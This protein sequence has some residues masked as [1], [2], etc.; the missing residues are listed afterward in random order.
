MGT[1]TEHAPT[2]NGLGVRVGLLQAPAHAGRRPVQRPPVVGQGDHGPAQVAVGRRD[3]AGGAG[4]EEVEGRLDQATGA[5]QLIGERG[6]QPRQIDEQD[7][8]PAH[9]SHSNRMA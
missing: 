9:G 6:A 8:L 7:R 3:D 4:R 1:P 5:Q 2:A